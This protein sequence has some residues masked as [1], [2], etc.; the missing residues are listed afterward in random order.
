MPVI[1]RLTGEIH[2]AQIFV[3]ALGHSGY[4]FAEATLSQAACVF[5]GCRSSIPAQAGP[6]IRVMPVQW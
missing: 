3:A 5:R 4:T 2:P 1:D 6:P